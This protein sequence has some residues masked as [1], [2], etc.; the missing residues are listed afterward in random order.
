[1]RVGII[2]NSPH[3][4]KSEPTCSAITDK[5]KAAPTLDRSELGNLTHV[6]HAQ[7]QFEDCEDWSEKGL[8]KRIRK[9]Q[10][11]IS[12]ET[13]F[14]PIIKGRLFYFKSTPGHAPKPPGSPSFA[15][16]GALMYVPVGFPSTY[17]R[18]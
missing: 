4:I 1:M 15:I 12:F 16:S 13:L 9:E 18:P 6:G 11:A 14:L 17:G 7:S 8:Q 2:E 3:N 10:L 5:G